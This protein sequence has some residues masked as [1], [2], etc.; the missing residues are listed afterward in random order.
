MLKM[1]SMNSKLL[2][3]INFQVQQEVIYLTGF[4]NRINIYPRGK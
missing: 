3:T 4:I 2:I 1:N